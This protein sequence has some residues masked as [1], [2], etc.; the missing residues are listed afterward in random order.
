M[1]ARLSG[2]SIYRSKRLKLFN[3]C[4]LYSTVLMFL[5]MMF[6]TVWYLPKITVMS[7]YFRIWG[8]CY[9]FAFVTNLFTIIFLMK[10]LN[11]IDKI[12]KEYSQLLKETY[13]MIQIH[14]ITF[15]FLVGVLVLDFIAC[16]TYTGSSV[17]IVISLSLTYVTEGLYV[18]LMA[19]FIWKFNAKNV[20]RAVALHPKKSLLS[21]LQVHRTFEEAMTS[22]SYRL[23]VYQTEQELERERLLDSAY[24]GHRNSLQ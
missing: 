12:I 5:T 14:T 9:I 24:S 7:E 20:E 13:N 22:E 21:Y 23:E 15:T 6:S 8:I 10:A 11:R 2:Q 4:V 1:E 3:L 18:L 19:Y 17:F 16:F